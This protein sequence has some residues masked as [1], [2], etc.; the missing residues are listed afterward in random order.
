MI[1]DPPGIGRSQ[2]KQVEVS[3]RKQ[4]PTQ[5]PVRQRSPRLKRQQQLGVFDD[6]NQQSCRWS[7]PPTLRDHFQSAGD[8]SETIQRESPVV[9]RVFMK[10]MAERRHKMR[11]ASRCQNA[12]DFP[13]H[14]FRM[15]HM[16]QHGIAFDTLKQ[17]VGKWQLLRIRRHIHSRN[18]QQVHIHRTVYRA[19]GSADIEIPATQRE[20]LRLGRVHDKWIR[21]QQQP[22]QAVAPTTRAP[23]T[24]KRFERTGHLRMLA[25]RTL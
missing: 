11:I 1:P 21:R 24:I 15:A 10:R 20:I 18:R 12:P 3:Q 25:F 2:E 22:A 16:L 17:A 9:L 23:L 4:R 14:L 6:K 13:D 8:F 19:P 7:R 5:Y